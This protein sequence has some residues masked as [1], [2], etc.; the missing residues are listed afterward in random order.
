MATE[1][2]E[3]VP[4][5]RFVL[6]HPLSGE[7]NIRTALK[8]EVY[9]PEKAFGFLR[10][11]TPLGSTG[12]DKG[13]WNISER[14]NYTTPI[15]L[16]LEGDIT[17][18]TMLGIYDRGKTE[19]S[20]VLRVSDEPIDP[21]EF[22]SDLK[23]FTKHYIHRPWIWGFPSRLLTDWRGQIAGLVAGTAAVTAVSSM[24]A[25]PEGR[26]DAAMLGLMTGITVTTCALLAL[27]LWSERF[28]KRRVANLDQYMAGSS[29]VQYLT[30]ERARVNDLLTE[31]DFDA[32][33]KT[34]GIAIEPS[35]C[36]QIY[37]EMPQSLVRARLDERTQK[38]QPG[39]S[40]ALPRMVN[41][42]RAM[43]QLSAWIFQK[44]D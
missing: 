2:L 25:A 1:T 22:K 3:K 14:P 21:N 42:A 4:H 23:A 35:L 27:D 33:L 26:T 15:V 13:V 36:D 41:V 10:V 34:S 31:R 38:V 5:K 17:T 28:A 9:L 37:R 43:P 6:P 11:S 20:V 24:L 12:G 7:Q 39:S 16:E 40:D 8:E 18:H 32:A 30:Q 19:N 44:S 29:A